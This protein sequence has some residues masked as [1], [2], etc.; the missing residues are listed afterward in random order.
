MSPWK[1]KGLGWAS[2]LPKPCHC[3][4]V[5]N[6]GPYDVSCSVRGHSSHLR[7]PGSNTGYC[8]TAALWL[9]I[10]SSSKGP[11]SQAARQGP[12]DPPGHHHLP[13][14]GHFQHHPPVP[15][16][17]FPPPPK[18]LSLPQAGPM[19]RPHYNPWHLT[20]VIRQLMWDHVLSVR[21]SWQ[22]GAHCG[23]PHAATRAVH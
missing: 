21:V 11:R 20:H 22:P 15:P 4:L 9:R 17:G 19:H 12:C 1:I 6:D 16:C 5:G 7:A 23:P 3:R 8:V 13:T 18:F 2:A 14:T 10:W